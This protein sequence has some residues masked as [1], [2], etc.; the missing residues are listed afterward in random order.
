MILTNDLKGII[1]KNGYSQRKIAEMLGI[2]EKTFYAK[3]KKG[4]FDSDEITEMI[5]ILQIKNPA[6][7]FFAQCVTPQVTDVG[8][9]KGA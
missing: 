9:Q 6:E 3:M 5:R 8:E 1:A 4:V 2:T 7:I